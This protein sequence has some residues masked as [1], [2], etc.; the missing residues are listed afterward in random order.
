MIVT[1]QHCFFFNVCELRLDTWSKAAETQQNELFL[2]N[3]SCGFGLEHHAL[4]VS[5]GLEAY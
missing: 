3:R 4:F 2:K 1:Y 5:G